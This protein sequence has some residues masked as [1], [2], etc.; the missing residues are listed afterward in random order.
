MS[1]ELKVKSVAV[2]DIAAVEHAVAQARNRGHNVQLVANTS[3]RLWNGKQKQCP[4]VIKLLDKQ[5]DVG[6]EE[7]KDK[8]GQYTLC[9]D[10]WAGEVYKVLGKPVE[11]IAH[12]S[13]H[14]KNL[15]GY[16]HTTE[17]LTL[18]N[19][20]L[21]LTDYHQKTFQRGASS[22]GYTMASN[23]TINNKQVMKYNV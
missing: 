17:E 14:A 22:H 11:G 7:I 23:Q 16:K 9:F 15:T 21:F 18:S 20:N 8:P 1:Q 19:V 5:F 2:Q 12:E 13:G 3:C 10:D 4:Y 6:L